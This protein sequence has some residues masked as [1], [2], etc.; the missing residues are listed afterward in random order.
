MHRE[1][2][3]FPKEKFTFIF[4][5]PFSKNEPFGRCSAALLNRSLRVSAS[6]LRK[7]AN[8]ARRQSHCVLSLVE[9]AVPWGDRIIYRLN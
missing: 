7:E 8:T 3:I 4:A 9:A 6:P 5:L 2:F 1:N